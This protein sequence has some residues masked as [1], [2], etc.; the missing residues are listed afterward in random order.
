MRKR[1]CKKEKNKKGQITIFVILAIVIILAAVLI[2]YFYP[3]LDFVRGEAES[4]DRFMQECIQESL[5]E[6]VEMIALQGGSLNPE[7]Y[8]IYEGN[9][10]EYLCYTTQNYAYCVMQQPM[11]KKHIEEELQ[12]S[13]NG[14]V[15]NC[16]NEMRE[17]F[18]S[19]GYDVQ[20][21]KGNYE[22]ELLPNR[23]VGHL[24]SEITLTRE[25]SQKYENFDVVLNN[26]LY[27]LMSIANS[28]LNSEAR[29]G[30]ADPV[31][32]MEYYR[33][34]KV[35]KK[36]QTDGTTIYILTDKDN[37]NKFQFASRSVAIPGGY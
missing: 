10:V 30:D 16:W 12:K 20:L 25:Q 32:Y 19:R 35:E 15:E 5:E 14:V 8:F 18:E 37:G 36:K 26:N 4:P 29:F 17:S 9:N 11:L 28:I 23:I 27:E 31:V 13:S 22:I 1:E 34:L 24:N 2:Y 6:N 21:N 7:N 33:D 3:K